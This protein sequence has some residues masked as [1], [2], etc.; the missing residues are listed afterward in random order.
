MDRVRTGRLPDAA[1]VDV[2]RFSLAA[3]EHVL[4]ALETPADGGISLGIESAGTSIAELDE[5]VVGEALAYDAMLEPG[6]YELWLRPGTVSASPYS[7]SVQRQ[8]PFT[9]PAA[10]GPPIAALPVTLALTTDVSEV[11]AYWS[12]GQRVAGQLSIANTGTTEQ[13]LALDAVT[14]HYAWS[15]TP[16][17]GRP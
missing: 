4:I 9:P 13:T 14:S 3:R 8:D 11:A 10:S 12:A 7:L 17:V 1:D 15:A 2:Y 16:G 6:D 5:A